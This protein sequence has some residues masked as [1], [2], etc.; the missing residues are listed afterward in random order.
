MRQSREDPIEYDAWEPT[1]YWK[2]ISHLVKPH[3]IV[4]IACTRCFYLLLVHKTYNVNTY[5]RSL[6][7]KNRL[8]YL[9]S[10][11]VRTVEQCDLR[12]RLRTIELPEARTGSKQRRTKAMESEWLCLAGE[13]PASMLIAQHD[14]VQA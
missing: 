8:T 12:V 10:F 6:E 13:T 5:Q 9:T 14:S 2:A 3:R 4:R 1:N 11:K 7:E